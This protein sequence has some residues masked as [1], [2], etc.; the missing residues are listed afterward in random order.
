MKKNSAGEVSITL[1]MES[2]KMQRQLRAIAKHTEALADELL[3]IDQEVCPECGSNN[4]VTTTAH[5]DG[6]AVATACA[7]DDCGYEEAFDA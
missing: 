3:E 6:H 5:A 4:Y 2:S 1:D 7:C